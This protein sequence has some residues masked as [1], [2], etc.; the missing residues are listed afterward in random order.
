MP[1]KDFV[2]VSSPGEVDAQLHE[3]QALLSTLPNTL[4][5][6]DVDQSIYGSLVG[7]VPDPELVED[8]GESSAVNAALER[9]FGHRK[10]VLKILERGKSIESVVHVLELYLKQFSDNVIL[11]KWLIDL[12]PKREI[13][14][15]E[16]KRLEDLKRKH[17]DSD[18]STSAI[19]LDE[20][21][22]AGSD[23]AETS[24]SE[25]PPSPAVSPAQ[26]P[27]TSTV[28]RRDGAKSAKKKTKRARRSHK[29]EKDFDAIPTEHGDCFND[30]IFTLPPK[31]SHCGAPRNEL[32]DQLVIPCYPKDKPQADKFH[33]F[34]CIASALCDTSF[35]NTKR[36]LD[37]IFKH[38][39]R[40]RV[41]R[42][43]KPNLH[44]EAERALSRRAPS[45]NLSPE[46]SEPVEE[47]TST[48]LNEIG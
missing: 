13:K 20:P 31:I 14:L 8:L 23:F 3:L 4:P 29:S 9:I 43:W 25:K 39:V 32:A 36:Q 26:K 45:A 35:Q 1:E 30:I 5:I 44:T 10:D 21:G 38:A 11:Q 28:A 12:R 24:D 6:R 33:H 46:L 22:S 18:K 27:R 40:C 7:F 37:C 17:E 34:R 15:T 19:A 42:N 41:L 48:M 16:K 47:D 2:R